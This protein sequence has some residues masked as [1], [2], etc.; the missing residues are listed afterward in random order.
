[1][2]C[3]A[4]RSKVHETF[5]VRSIDN[6]YIGASKLRADFLDV[7]DESVSVLAGGA[8]DSP[9]IFK[10]NGLSRFVRRFGH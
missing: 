10:A 5:L 1:M 4:I 9:V 6:K 7:E 2:P 3:G 8:R